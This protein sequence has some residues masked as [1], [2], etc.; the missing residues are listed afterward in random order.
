MLFRSYL[1]FKHAQHVEYGLT[2]EVSAKVGRLLKELDDQALIVVYNLKYEVPAT[3][4]VF[5]VSLENVID[6]MQYTIPLNSKGS[7]KDN[8]RTYMRVGQW[9][10]GV[11]EYKE[12]ADYVLQWLKPTKKFRRKEEITL[13]DQGIEALVQDLLSRKV[14]DK[15][16]RMLKSIQTME[17]KIGR[18]HV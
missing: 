9:E 18:A 6:C 11:E 13:T 14:E 16:A 15:A 5:G 12:A 3:Y 4:R 1:W 8:A 2:E 17:K 10:K 7:L